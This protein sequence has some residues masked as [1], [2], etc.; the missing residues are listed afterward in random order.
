VPPE[1]GIKSTHLMS[2]IVNF[3]NPLTLT[4]MK[5]N[6]KEIATVAKKMIITN[7]K[8]R[9]IGP[10]KAMNNLGWFS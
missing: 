7:L 4:P 9:S 10:P 5:M 6:K 2:Q 3:F 1:I 8:I